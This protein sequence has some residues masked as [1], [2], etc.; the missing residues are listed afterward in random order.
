MPGVGE[1]P[2][3]GSE[4]GER[5]WDAVLDYIGTRDDLDPSRVAVYGSSTGG[6]WATKV[7]HTHRDRIRAAV[8]HGGMA[9]LALAE[10]WI[11]QAQSGEYPFELAETLASAFGRSTGEEW[12]DLAPRLSLLTQGVLDQPSAPLLLVNGI[13]DTV[14][15]IADMYLLLQHG[16]PKTARFFE[17]GHMG[18]S[19]AQRV[20]VEWLWQQLSS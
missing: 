13:H 1:A 5:L 15:P 11:L 10:K 8:N 18:G 2:I 9:H 14:F 20:I 7:A 6:Y 3:A 17:A 19:G 16:S 4:D 12:V